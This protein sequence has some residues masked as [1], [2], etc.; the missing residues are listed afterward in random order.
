VSLT[1]AQ[2]TYLE[3]NH[4]A[5]MITLRP[6]GTP[7]AVRIGLALVDGQLWS[8]GTQDRRRTANLRR[9]PRSTLFVYEGAGFRYLTIEARVA[10][11]EGPDAPELNLHLFRVMQ[12][13]PTGPILWNGVDTPEPEFLTRMLAEK[14]LIYQFDPVRAYGL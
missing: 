8:S 2:R 9:D 4:G 14:R 5:A 7:T 6:D 1:E 10:I 3:Q 12:N 11:L 13:R